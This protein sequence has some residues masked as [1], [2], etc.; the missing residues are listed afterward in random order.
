MFGVLLVCSYVLYL[1]LCGND[2]ERGA[3]RVRS[4]LEQ[5]GTTQ[6]VVADGVIEFENGV[7]VIAEGISASES[8]IDNATKAVEFLEGNTDEARKLI[9]RCQRI[10]EE[11]RARSEKGTQ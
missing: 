11:V 9:D 10:I 4:E 8:R 5:I 2:H 7:A 1:M 6:R 3:E